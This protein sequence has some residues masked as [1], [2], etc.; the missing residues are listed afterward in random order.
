MENPNEPQKSK[1]SEQPHYFQWGLTAFC[2]IGCCVLVA[3]VLIK[4]PFIWN[5]VKK[6]FGALSPFIYGFVMAYLLMPVFNMLYRRIQPPMSRKFTHGTRIAKGISSLLTL[7]IGLAVV[8]GL[9]W[10][11]LPQLVVSVFSI[12][13]SADT[14]MNDVSNWVTGLLKDNPVIARNFMQVYEQFSEQLVNWVQNIALPHLVTMMTGVVT[15]VSVV[16]DILIGIIIALYI[17]NG[18]ET[19]CAQAKKMTYSLFSIERANSIIERVAYIHR[20]FGG[21]ITGKLID[22]LIIGVLCFIGMRVMMSVGLLTIESSFALLI[23][24]IIGV[25]NIIPFFG[26]FI[27]AVPSAILIMVTSPLQALYFVI[28]IIIL[29]QID[30]NILGPKILGN[31]TGLSSFWVMFAILIFGGLFGFVGMAI[32]VPLFA[33]IY[34]IVSECINHLLHNRGLSEDTNDYRGDKRLDAGTGQFVHVS[35]NVPPVSA[36]ERRAAAK[37]KEQSKNENNEKA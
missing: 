36:R 29:Q 4:L 35:S 16:V 32:G 5:V 3:F 34:S 25:T 37:A 7:I 22:S 31:S 15:T 10:M 9:L 21:F 23:S 2:V 14:Y 17:L 27:G 30:G 8:A 1:F 18:K 11:V 19:F 6:L 28:F 12:V 24:V 26:P 20:V 33:V 13:E